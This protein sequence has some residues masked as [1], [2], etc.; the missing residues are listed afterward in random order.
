M[1]SSDKTI[2]DN[3]AI[4]LLDFAYLVA[5]RLSVLIYRVG[6]RIYAEVYYPTRFYRQ[7]DIISISQVWSIHGS[8]LKPV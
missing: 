4:F 5:C 8:L 1:D 2:I 7:F 3:A 6:Q